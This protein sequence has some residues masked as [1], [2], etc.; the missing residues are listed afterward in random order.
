MKITTITKLDDFRCDNSTTIGIQSK[1]QPD[2]NLQLVKVVTGEVFIN[3]DK[4]VSLY[5]ISLN[6]MKMYLDFEGTLKECFE[7]LD[8][9]F[10][11]YSFNTFADFYDW[12]TTTL[13]KS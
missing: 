1:M 7:N 5:R 9:Y 2:Y 13:C 11:I 8:K 4:V 6:D 12:Y 3:M 10:H